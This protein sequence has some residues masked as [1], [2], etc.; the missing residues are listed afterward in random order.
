LASAII[1]SNG[2]PDPK[3]FVLENVCPLINDPSARVKNFSKAL[4]D[5]IAE[6]GINVNWE[7]ALENELKP[8]Q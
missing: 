3:G 2:S 7:K 6:Q 5:R 1:E 4:Y 8:K